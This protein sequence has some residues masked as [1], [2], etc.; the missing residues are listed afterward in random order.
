MKD[1]FVPFNRFFT[2]YEAFERE[3]VNDII[4]RYSS[5]DQER[6]QTISSLI[7]TRQTR[8][9]YELESL[10]QKSQKLLKQLKG[11]EI[12]RML[13]EIQCFKDVI[14]LQKRLGDKNSQP[15]H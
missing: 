4:R 12:Q 5:T 11:I 10:S 1:D 9:D 3:T 14:A 8:R 2:K 13:E 7:E 6:R 15:N